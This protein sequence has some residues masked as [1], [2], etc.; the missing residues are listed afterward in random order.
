MSQHIL[1]NATI[2][3]AEGIA[4]VNYTSWNE[5]Y[6]GLIDEVYLN[7]LTLGF[8]EKKW[9]RIINTRSAE[10]FTRVLKTAEGTLIGYCSGGRAR[11]AF[12]KAEGEIYAL[13]LLK[14][15]QGKGLG[16]QL[17]LDG[18][19]QLQQFGHSSCSLFVLKDNPTVNFYRKFQPD[20]I[21]PA[22]VKIDQQEYD[23]LGMVWSDIKSINGGTKR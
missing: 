21:E 12:H 5:T 9:Q 18:I 14:Q 22:K 17:F 11:E 23:D 6:R 15:H 10:G 20:I 7:S 16:A 19:N 3:D 1:T 13:Y 4:F 2:D 8:Y